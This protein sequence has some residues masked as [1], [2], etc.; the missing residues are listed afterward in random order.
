MAER[1]IFIILI[2]MRDDKSKT[3]VEF[4]SFENRQLIL[5][6]EKSGDSVLLMQ[7]FLFATLENLFDEKMI[8]LDNLIIWRF[9]QNKFRQEHFIYVALR[10]KETQKEV[11]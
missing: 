1:N 7:E 11:N 4:I 8:S 5:F 3:W 2:K 6:Q 10:A 9:S